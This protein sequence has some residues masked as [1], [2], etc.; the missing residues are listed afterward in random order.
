MPATYIGLGGLSGGKLKF[1]YAGA[2]YPAV[3]PDNPFGIPIPDES[4]FVLVTQPTGTTPTLVEIGMNPPV[5]AQLEPGSSAHFLQVVFTT[6]DETPPSSAACGVK[7]VV[8]L[9]PPPGIDAVINA[10]SRQQ[11][12]SPGT[13]VLIQGSHLTGPTLS[14]TNDPRG[15]Y[16]TSVASTTVTFN[17]ITAPLLRVSP[18]QIR[19]IVPFALAGQTSAEV[20]VQRFS[21]VS[22]TFTV[23]LQDTSPGIFTR[24]RTGAGQ[25]AI[26]QQGS[27]KNFTPN[28]PDN[29]ATAWTILKVFATGMGVW[30]PPAPSDVLVFGSFFKT[31]PVSVTIG[32]QPAKVLYASTSADRKRW[33]VLEVDVVVP[34]GL[35]S[36]PQP[37]V[38]AIGNNDSSQ[39]QVTVAIQ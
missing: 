23:P 9:E 4:N 24:T 35:S 19:A 12:F 2:F 26:L 39:Q 38:L 22:D 7:L 3:T 25:G 14:T 33:S 18:S 11:F 32:G 13:E 8:P 6:V 28:G 36:G 20:V 31:Q 10:A 30:T 5:V 17:G 29:P 1:R 21:K 16:P 15:Y 34:D 37:V 27:D